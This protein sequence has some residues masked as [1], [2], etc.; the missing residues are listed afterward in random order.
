[1]K[2]VVLALLALA[3]LLAPLAACGNTDQPTGGD[4]PPPANTNSPDPAPANSPDPA[5]AA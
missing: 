4:S 1:M 5:P 2:K 3:L